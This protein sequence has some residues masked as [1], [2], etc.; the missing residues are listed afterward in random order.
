M[1][2]DHQKHRIRGGNTAGI[3]RQFWLLGC[4]T[5]SICWLGITACLANERPPLR[6]S[7]Q[8]N[9]LTIQGPQLPGET[10]QVW[11]LEAYCGPGSTHQDWDKSVI[12]HQTQLVSASSDGRELRLRCTISDGVI[13]DHVITATHD[14]IDF[15]ITAHNPSPVASQ[16]QWAQPCMRVDKF[17]GRDQQSYLDKCFVFTNGKLQRMP[18]SEWSSQALYTP[19]QVWAAPG[20]DRNDVNPRPLNANTPSC[21]LI[22]CFSNDDSMLLATAYEPYQELFQGIITCIHADF[23]IGGLQPGETKRIHG[24]LYIM[25]NDV[26]ALVE[27]YQ[28]DFPERST[29]AGNQAGNEATAKWDDIK[30]FFVVPDEYQGKLGEYRSLLT[31]DS[32]DAHGA[33]QVETPEDWA[34]RRQEIREYWLDAIGQWPE[35]LERPRMNILASEHVGSYTRH[36]IE[37]EVAADRSIGPEYLLVPDGQGPF[38]AVVV[39]WYNSA[40]AAGLTE[41]LLGTRDF[42]AQLAERGY[43]TLCL[44]S[45]N[46]EDVRQPTL[47]ES[48]QPLAYLAYTAASTCNLL[49]TLPYVQADRIGITGHS[50]GGKWAMYASCLHDKFACAVWIDPGIVWNE[51]D[52]NAN[53]WDP[54]YLGQDLTRPPDQQRPRGLVSDNNSRTGAYRTLVAEHRDMHELHALMAPRPFLVSGGEQDRPE[55]WIALNHSIAINKLLGYTDRVAMTMRDGHSPTPESLEQAYRFFDYF[56]K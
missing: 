15:Q 5:L 6:L 52:P 14:E 25:A 36:T 23:R 50:Y 4:L 35:L 46:G 9:I 22:G 34:L 48:I 12:P 10:L 21:G 29:D 53:Y 39:T 17:T 45:T 11:Y 1:Y 7:W 24:K 32:D 3:I 40:D 16:V 42:G 54:W 41:K 49:A 18:T 28:A 37:V 44:G 31:F 30:E 43:V 33:K 38:P 2:D 13:V 20:V 19:G 26:A 51:V 56:L 47:Y 55:H 8:D 27:R